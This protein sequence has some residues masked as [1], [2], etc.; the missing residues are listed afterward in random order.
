MEATRLNLAKTYLN[1]MEIL[2]EEEIDRRLNAMSERQRAYLNRMEIIAYALNQLPPLYATGEKG[3]EFQLS[4]GR[5]Q[6]TSRIQRAVHQAL[7][8]VLRD[9][10]LTYKPIRIE[11]PAG[12]RDVLKRIRTLLKNDQADW[13]SVPEILEALMR[14]SAEEITIVENASGLSAY[15]NAIP[16][17]IKPEQVRSDKDRPWRRVPTRVG[18]HGMASAGWE[19]SRYWT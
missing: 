9:P 3:L 16:E 18:V 12:L 19:D 5:I 17:Q 15:T 6:H 7:A 10:I 14:Q 13:D 8:A 1:A 11:A 2:V 4:Q